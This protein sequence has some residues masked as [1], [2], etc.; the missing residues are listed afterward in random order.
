MRKKLGFCVI[1]GLCWGLALASCSSVDEVT[2]SIDCHTV[3]QRYADC[4][5]SDYDVDGCSD[6]CE[7][8]AD[9]ADDRQRKLKACDT[10]IGTGGISMTAWAC[11]R[12]ITTAN[13][14]SA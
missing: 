6:R 4:F 8:N 14:R 11:P 3:C 9:S 12:A 10:C 13:G 7:T 5:N 2:N 1:L